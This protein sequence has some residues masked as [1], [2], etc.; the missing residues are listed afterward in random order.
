MK[1]NV[2]KY[3]AVFALLLFVVL[4]VSADRI[5]SIYRLGLD[6]E[7]QASDLAQSN[8]DH[9]KG[10]SGA[11]SDQEQAVLFKSEAFAASCRLFLRLTEERSDYFIAGH[12]RT[13]LYNAF[14]YLTRAFREFEGEMSKVRI[15]P[16]ALSDCRRILDRVDKE[17]AKWPSADNLAYLH[18]KYV[19][20]RDATV[21]MI[22]REGPGVY[23]RHAFKNLESLYR[24]NYDLKRGKNPWNYLVQVS[25][26][27][28]DKM[29]EGSMIDLNFEGY[30]IIEQSNRPNRPVYLIQNGKKR[31]LTS[32]RVL[33]RYGG[34]EKVYEVPVEVVNEYPEG[35]PIN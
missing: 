3:S 18:E 31:G 22:E 5:E 24:Y 7:R 17:F 15:Q 2:L 19:K 11:I 28:L 4:S 13:N 34:W 21:H 30:L 8:Y 1:K 25:Y 35:E 29:E 14:I 26:D 12:L 23:V 16:Y 20:A 32:P 27:T 9:F 33:Q 10:W 6:L